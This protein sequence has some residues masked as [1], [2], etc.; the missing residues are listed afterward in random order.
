MTE[1]T[2][3]LLIDSGREAFSELGLEGARVDRIAA[4]AGMNKALINY[5]FRGKEGLYLAVLGDLLEAVATELEAELLPLDDAEARLNAWPAAFWAAMERRP[6]LAPLLLREL[7]SGCRGLT[8]ERL[9]ALG[10]SWGLMADGLRGPGQTPFPT[11]LALMGALLIAQV[12]GPLQ[13]PLGE[14]LGP[15]AAAGDRGQVLP[16]LRSLTPKG[17][18]G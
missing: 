1:A 15:E 2:R 6:Q 5:H 12:A 8:D 18:P 4:S 11:G 7:L 13:G 3:Q 9:S 14:A 16:L 17:P 10:R